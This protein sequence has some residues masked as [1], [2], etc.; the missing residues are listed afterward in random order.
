MLGDQIELVQFSFA[1]ENDAAGQHS[2]LRWAYSRK[3]FAFCAA[4]CYS[5]VSRYRARA[6]GPCK[7]GVE[8]LA[9]AFCCVRAASCFPS[10]AGAEAVFFFVGVSA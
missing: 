7:S 2:L 3:G 10:S 4:Q 9:C 8:D 6:F 1:R 5:P